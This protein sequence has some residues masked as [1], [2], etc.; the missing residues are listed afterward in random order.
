MQP[1][2]WKF[3]GRR[4]VGRV[5]LGGHAV[6]AREQREIRQREHRRRAQ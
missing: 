6:A 1:V 5:D 3:R 2:P 4:E